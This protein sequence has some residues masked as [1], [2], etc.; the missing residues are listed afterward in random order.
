MKRIARFCIFSNLS[1]SPLR[2]GFQIVAPYS[3]IIDRTICRLFFYNFLGRFQG[4]IQDFK[5][6]GGGA[7]KK[8]CAERREARKILGCFV[9]K[10]TILCQKIIFFPILGGGARRVRPS[11]WIRPWFLRFLLRKPRV[12]LA[13]LHTLLICMLHLRSFEVWVFAYFLKDVVI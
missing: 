13:F 5:L 6:G 7:L 10:I 2:Y 12:A 11:P 8:K 1:M 3:A 9:W 4:R